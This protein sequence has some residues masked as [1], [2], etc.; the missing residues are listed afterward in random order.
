M[1]AK[2]GMDLGTAFVKLVKL[3]GGELQKALIL[4]NPL[5]KVA[6]E[7]GRDVTVMVE[8]IKKG[9]ADWGGVGKQVGL[10]L[11]DNVV[12]TTVINLPV[13]SD[14]ELASALQWEAEQYVPMA[15][16]EVELSWEVLDRPARRMGGE[17]MSIL[18]VAA[19]KRIV[20]GL[21]DVSSSLGLE[22]VSIEPELVASSRAV[23]ANKD[24]TVPVILASF[25]AAGVSMGVFR[26]NKLLFVSRFNSGGMAMTRAISQSLQLSPTQAEEYK[27]TYGVKQNV[28]ENKLS[29]AM[30]PVLN[31]LVEEVR[32]VLLYFEQQFAGEKLTRMLMTG[33]GALMPGLLVYL[34]EKTGLEVA[35]GDP[36]KL[37]KLG[38]DAGGASVIYAA[39]IGALLR[40]HGA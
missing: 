16:S 15:L 5:G 12:Y 24:Q 38:K 35:L 27:R 30:G 19:S 31:G 1:P 37:I 28:L 32:R 17:K 14:T 25:G 33:G 13:L 40:N 2:L 20:Q 36:F 18:L 21:V 4:S 29:G 22:P 23:Y 9:I 6:F 11:S 8:A 10:V 3:D 7:S 26:N 34:S 39:A